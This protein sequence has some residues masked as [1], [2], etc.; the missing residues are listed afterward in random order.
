MSSTMRA[1]G[2]DVDPSSGS[3]DR[4]H[5]RQRMLA[6]DK[7]QLLSDSEIVTPQALQKMRKAISAIHVVPLKAEHA[8]SL[9]NRR[10]FDACILV[11]QGECKKKGAAYIQRVIQ[12]RISPLFDV[13]ISDL[14]RIANIAG[15]NYIRIYEELDLLY[16]MSFRWNVVGED[17]SI[18]WEMKGHFFS[19]LGYGNGLKRGLVRF[20]LDPAILTMILE[21]A[22]WASL[23]ISVMHE[24][25]TPASYALYQN[26]WR[27]VGTQSKVT[28]LL[29]TEI[30]AE[31]LTG[32]GGYV[33]E[34]SHDG[35][36]LVRYADFKR[37]ILNDAI[38]RINEISELDYKLE[39]REIKSANRVVKL[40]F[41][42][43]AKRIDEAED[44]APAWP[45]DLVKTLESLGYSE[46]E[47]IQL[48]KMATYDEVV[49][50]L[51]RFRTAQGRMRATG[52]HVESKKAY[53]QGILSRMRDEEKVCAAERVRCESELRV[54]N[55]EKNAREHDDRLREEFAK[56]IFDTFIHNLFDGPADRLKGLILDFEQ[57][58]DARKAE[59]L[60][61]KGWDRNNRPLM[62]IVRHWIGQYRQDLMD[63]LLPYPYQ[64][65]FD[66]WRVWQQSGGGR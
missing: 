66:R 13:H 6:S 35:K 32:R 28:A 51:S 24:L 44:G 63:V 47:I 49:E 34:D 15:K 7:Q 65:S 27:Y 57:T 23:S 36:K 62:A 42:F 21:P 38:S 58:D 53:L 2:G 18:E 61:R 4:F 64:R 22:M 17:S 43:V 30:W 16:E 45:I 3:V 31:L 59:M 50:S 11:V 1:N 56:Y 10:L 40:Q 26:A 39:L 8:Q 46:S 12:D 25:K 52:A 5:M 48:S 55:E 54:K 29:T 9:N 37:R 41:K 60:L 14:A 19:S 33:E 20:S